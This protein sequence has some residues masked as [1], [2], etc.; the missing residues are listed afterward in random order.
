M[1]IEVVV[2]CDKVS[3]VSFVATRALLSCVFCAYTDLPIYLSI[4]IQDTYICM[5]LDLRYVFNRQK[6][7]ITAFR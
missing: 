2:L 4:Y 1:F 5:R 7:F 6:L 3:C